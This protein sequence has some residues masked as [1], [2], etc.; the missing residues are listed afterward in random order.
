MRWS[1]VA[2]NVGTGDPVEDAVDPISGV[3][4][5]DAEETVWM[6]HDFA[7]S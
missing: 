3:V 2:E 1:S 4:I 5:R 7:G 6:T